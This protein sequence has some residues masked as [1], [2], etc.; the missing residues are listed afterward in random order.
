MK[1]FTLEN[2]F[3]RQKRVGVFA[4]AGF[5]RIICQIS[6]MELFVE[7]VY[8]IYNGIKYFRKKRYLR[9]LTGLLIHLRGL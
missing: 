7:I 5:I 8:I 2:K 9:F 6:E 4:M 1:F 3:N